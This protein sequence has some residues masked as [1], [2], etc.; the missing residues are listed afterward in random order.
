MSRTL[1]AS[2][3][4]RGRLRK[5]G[6]ELRLSLRVTAAA[7]VTFALSEFFDLPLVLWPVLTPSS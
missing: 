1:P 5:R 7:L 6:A 4:A 3:L 2:K